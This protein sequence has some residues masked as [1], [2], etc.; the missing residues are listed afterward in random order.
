MI[1]SCEILWDKQDRSTGEAFVIFDNPKA[2]KEAI[3]SL[4]NSMD[5][6]NIFNIVFLAEL[7]GQ[8]I[9]M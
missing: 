3:K 6:F 8:T 5:I 2:A 1:N 9:T 4:N 7:E